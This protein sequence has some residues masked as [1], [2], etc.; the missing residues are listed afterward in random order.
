[1]ALFADRAR[2]GGVTLTLDEQTGSLVVSVCR[3]LD[4]MP[5]AI[6][7]AAAR[8][9]SMSL[10][11]LAGRLDQRFRLLTGGSRTALERQ[12][13]LAATV[14]WSYSLL[15]GAEQLLLAR[16]SVFAGGFGLDAAE[17]VC[18]SGDLDVLDVADLLG[19]LVDKSLVV[20]EPA[21]GILR[22]RLL[23]TIRL[24]AA[25]RLAEAGEE[26]VAAVASA[27]CAHFLAVAETAAAY[28][29]GPEQGE[30]L[31]RLDADQANLHRAAGYAASLSDGT[32]LLLRLGAALDRYWWARSRQQ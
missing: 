13:T 10:A 26:E 14:G 23:E 3:R 12:Q 32:A 18:G 16:L 17:A 28:L 25:E 9:R 7:L 11:E 2:A 8:L 31:A 21:G 29:T 5:L 6:E 1:V 15:T 22:Y 30:W 27:H 19:S 24:F 20:A 4:G